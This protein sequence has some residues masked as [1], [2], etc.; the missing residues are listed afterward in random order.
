MLM[1][2]MYICQF[3]GQVIVAENTSQYEQL[4]EVVSAGEVQY[5]QA[6]PVPFSAAKGSV[7]PINQSSFYAQPYLGWPFSPFPLSVA[8]QHHYCPAGWALLARNALLFP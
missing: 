8:Y 7:S 2:D 3:S 5:G 4:V 1:C 6:P